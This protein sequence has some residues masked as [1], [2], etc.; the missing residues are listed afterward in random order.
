MPYKLRKAPGREL[1]WVVDINGKKY[2]KDPITK[3]KAEAQLK[4]LHIHTHK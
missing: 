2:S 1:Y 4:A 3:K